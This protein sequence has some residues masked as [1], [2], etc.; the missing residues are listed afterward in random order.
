MK[1]KIF[2][3][4]SDIA[5]YYQLLAKGLDELGYSVTLFHDSENIYT[6][7]YHLKSND[8]FWMKSSSFFRKKYVK[9]SFL[10]SKFFYFALTQ[11]SNFFIFIWAINKF[12]IFIFGFSKSF[13][14]GNFDLIILRKLKK[15]I[16]SNIGH[17][18]DARPGYIDGSYLDLKNKFY[19]N[20]YILFQSYV[21]KKQI[22]IIEKYSNY[23]IGSAYTSQYLH[24]KFISTMNI[25]S[26]MLIK[27][28]QE[29]MLSNYS[30]STLVN[31]LHA[32]SKRAS[33]G[34]TFVREA[35]MSL[36]NK[37]FK[38]NYVEIS[39]VTHQKVLEEIQKSDFV[40][41]QVFSDTLLAGF[42]SEAGLFGKP[43]IICGYGLGPEINKFYLNNPPPVFSCKPNELEKE[44][45]KLIN[46]KK[47]I[48]KK[49]KEINKWVFENF[50]YVKM[51]IKYDLILKNKVPESWYI[52]PLEVQYYY[53]FGY[54]KEA[55]K[56]QLKT[57]LKMFGKKAFM[58]KDRPQLQQE[59]I[60]FIEK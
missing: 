58:L 43:A 18:S 34:T 32:P 14:L 47:L 50:G 56:K 4:F 38:F 52:N 2:I 33:K 5:G 3:G 28:Q 45:E 44:I 17:G 53:G 35:I 59:I 39:G 55:L 54:E 29:N 36:K 30:K 23:I 7:N 21:T 37:G 19:F 41:D 20:Y 1:K 46:N 31:I 22:T 60:D 16:I 8:I 42:T 12:E 49:G 10:I 25:G 26:P 6:P 40:I 27:E 11:I 24:K 9:S 51:A 13:I 57:Y 15:V 48:R